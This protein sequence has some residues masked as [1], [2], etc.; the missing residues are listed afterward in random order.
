M[1]AEGGP[2]TEIYNGNSKW[3]QNLTCIQ[4]EEAVRLVVGWITFAY[5]SVHCFW[6]LVSTENEL[7]PTTTLM[8]D[9]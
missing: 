9:W 6:I 7:L 4:W 3:L 8:Y 5:I 2:S 1:V